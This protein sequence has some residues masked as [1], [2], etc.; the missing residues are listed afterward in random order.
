MPKYI[1]PNNEKNDETANSASVGLGS[2]LC[3]DRT[4]CLYLPRSVGDGAARV[5]GDW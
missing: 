1:N 5:A 4:P 3:I 2:R